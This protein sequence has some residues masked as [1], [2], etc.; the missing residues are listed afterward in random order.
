MGGKE[1]CYLNREDSL[2]NYALYC[3]CPHTDIVPADHEI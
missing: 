3:E 1:E 2:G